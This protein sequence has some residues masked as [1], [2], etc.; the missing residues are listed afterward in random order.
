MAK[1]IDDQ[2]L[3]FKMY[4][5]KGIII[6]LLLCLVCIAVYRGYVPS[7]SDLG[8][9]TLSF[10]VLIF[11]SLVIVLEIVVVLFQEKVW[12]PGDCIRLVGLTVVISFA[13][14]LATARVDVGDNTFTALIGFLG[15]IAGYLAGGMGKKQVE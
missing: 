5:I 1:D 10:S 9:S 3:I 8:I 2:N 13:I 4:V 14:F 15:T 11:G 12:D 6:S 7:A